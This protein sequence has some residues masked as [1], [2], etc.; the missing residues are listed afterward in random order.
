M[1]RESEEFYVRTEMK[2]AEVNRKLKKLQTNISKAERG[3][4]RILRSPI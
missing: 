2:G 3:A 4:E 1:K